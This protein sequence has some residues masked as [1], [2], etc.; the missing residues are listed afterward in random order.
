MPRNVVYTTMRR[1]KYTKINQKKY[2][3]NYITVTFLEKKKHPPSKR[4][5]GSK[6]K[7]KNR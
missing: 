1:N 7:T 5:N 4:K 6:T 2:K 3:T